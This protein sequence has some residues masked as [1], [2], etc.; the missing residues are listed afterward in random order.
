L[1]DLADGQ[2]EITPPVIGNYSTSWRSSWSHT[3]TT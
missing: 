2:E 3:D 1:I